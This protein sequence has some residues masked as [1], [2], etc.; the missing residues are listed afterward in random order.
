M[1]AELGEDDQ[2]ANLANV[3]VQKT[4]KAYKSTG[5]K[6]KEL[7]ARWRAKE[8]SRRRLI[9]ISQQLKI[10]DKE[11]E[12]RLHFLEVLGRLKE[13][14]THDDSVVHLHLTRLRGE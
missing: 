9:D 7:L 12:S 8:A 11:R 3:A 4:N 5:E 2:H 13:L 6:F 10:Y 14:N 1:R